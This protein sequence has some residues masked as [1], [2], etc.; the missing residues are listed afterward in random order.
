M[1][2]S[3]LNFNAIYL[4]FVQIINDIVVYNLLKIQIDSLQ[5]ETSTNFFSQQKFLSFQ[6]SRKPKF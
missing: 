3:S 4:K 2:S 5:I 6:G 1:V